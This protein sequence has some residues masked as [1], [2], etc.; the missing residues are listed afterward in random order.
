MIQWLRICLE[1]Q[2]MRVWSLIGELRAH[3]LRGNKAYPPQLE[4]WVTQ[5][6]P[7]A[8]KNNNNNKLKVFLKVWSNYWFENFYKILWS[9]N[10]KEVFYQCLC[11][12]L[13]LI[14][15]VLNK[16]TGDTSGKEPSCQGR[17]HEVQVWSLGWE[18]RL[19]KGMAIHSSILAWRILWTEEPGVL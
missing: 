3:M 13:K 19:Q 17:R 7:S 14:R 11:L 5:W 8:A 1:R 18:D 6:R 9:S 2:G 10:H 12:D 16:Q 15:S 4:A